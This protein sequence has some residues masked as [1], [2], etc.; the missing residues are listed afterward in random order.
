M[1]ALQSNLNQWVHKVDLFN[2]A[3]E[4]GGYSPETTCPILRRLEREGKIK[5]GEYDGKFRKNLVQ[6]CL[7]EPK[8]PFTQWEEIVKDNGERVMIPVKTII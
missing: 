3:Y 6:Y 7:G 8:K 2:I 1:E 4:K 5:K